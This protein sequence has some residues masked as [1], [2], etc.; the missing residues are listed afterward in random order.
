MHIA[1]VVIVL[2]ENSDGICDEGPSGG[3]PVYKASDH[4][5]VYGL[6]A[7]FFVGLPLVKLHCHRHGNWPGL[8]QSELRQDCPNVAVLIDVD[9]VMLPI[10]FDVDAEIEGDTPEIMHPEPLLH[11][12]L[13]MP[14]QAL[15]C[16]DQK[17]MDVQNDCGDGWAMILKHEQS[18]VNM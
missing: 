10:A 5:L 14:N 9:C 2:A 18:S 17:I 11:L 3:D 13:D 6:I 16:N 4:R 12:I 8:V 1:R 15:G 7:G